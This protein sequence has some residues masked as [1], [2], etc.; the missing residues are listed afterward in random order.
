MGVSVRVVGR[1]TDSV[2]RFARDGA[3][4]L[5]LHLDDSDTKQ[6]VRV[7]IPFADGSHAS[8]FIAGAQRARFRHQVVAVDA[9]NPRFK[10]S[11][12]D[13]EASHVAGVQLLLQG[14]A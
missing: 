10:K 4:S 8:Q 7:H 13:C 9:V 3:P 1:V 14:K 6:S 2:L 12:M 11:R 5:V